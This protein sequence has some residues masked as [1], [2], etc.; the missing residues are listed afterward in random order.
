MAPTFT[1]QFDYTVACPCGS[2]RE[3]GIVLDGF[4]AIVTVCH[5]DF[6]LVMAAG[7][8]LKLLDSLLDAQPV[9]GPAWRHPD[10]LVW[11]V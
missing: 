5:D 6:G 8:A 3:A 7:S 4:D 10:G 2:G 1:A 9:D 11:L